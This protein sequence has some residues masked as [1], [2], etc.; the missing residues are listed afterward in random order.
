[1][2]RVNEGD[3]LE[4]RFHNL[5]MP[6]VPEERTRGPEQYGGKVPARMEDPGGVVYPNNGRTGREFVKATAISND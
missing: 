6:A 3:C 5:L 4:V 1:M 2:L